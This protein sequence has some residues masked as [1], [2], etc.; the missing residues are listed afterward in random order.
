VEFPPTGGAVPTYTVRT[1]K[2]LRYVSAMDFFILA[3][4]CMF[5]LFI[6]YYVVE[7]I[8][9]VHFR[10]VFRGKA[11]RRPQNSAK[12]GFSAP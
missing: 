11:N 6:V 3:C 1:V 12:I 7:E 10:G 4:E 8:L 5:V 2:L 9:E